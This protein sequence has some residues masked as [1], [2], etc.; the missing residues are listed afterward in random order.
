[1]RRRRRVAPLLR[2]GYRVAYFGITG[3]SLLTAQRYRGVKCVVR[4]REGRV[5]FVRHTY[6]DR[7]AWELPGGHVR[8]AEDMLEGARREA[9]EELGVEI[10]AWEDLG[11]VHTGRHRGRVALTVMIA[12]LP[13][14]EGVD[15]AELEAAYHELAQIGEVTEAEMERARALI[16]SD[17]LHH[18]ATVD[19]RAD[20]FSQFT[21]L[22]DDPGLVNEMLPRVLAVT[23][24][25]VQDIAAEVIRPDN[26]VV[27][28]F[29]PESQSAAA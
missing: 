3:W 26:R 17:W 21:T 15:P 6:G 22:F 8:R 1:M 16:T 23:A 10:A 28:V 18:L 20:M 11:T 4:D 14:R 24:K 13:A 19:G 12:D 27:L 2:A 29:E 7:R 9:R 5:L 25:D